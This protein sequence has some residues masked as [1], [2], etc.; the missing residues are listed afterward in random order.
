MESDRLVLFGDGIE[1]DTVPLTWGQSARVGVA[2]RTLE[3]AA[4]NFAAA[5]RP[6]GPPM[7][8]VMGRS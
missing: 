1:A 6:G 7:T 8:G 4:L 3:P 2:A 5:P